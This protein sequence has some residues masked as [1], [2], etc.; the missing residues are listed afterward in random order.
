MPGQSE[1]FFIGIFTKFTQNTKG[2]WEV[3]E[4]N[5]FL[6]DENYFIFVNEN[7]RFHRRRPKN[8]PTPSSLPLT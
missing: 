4:P 3:T 8:W 5:G 1:Q 7:F 2:E 6:C